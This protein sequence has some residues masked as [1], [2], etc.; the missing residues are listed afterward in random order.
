[1]AFLRRSRRRALLLSAGVLAGCASG[2][3]SEGVA[4]P[5]RRDA[6]AAPEVGGEPTPAVS[7]TTRQGA[8]GK[9]DLGPE[10]AP[11]APK[12]ELPDDYLH[13]EGACDEGPVVTIAAV[14][15]LL[16]HR[17][18]QRQALRSK[19]GFRVL[20]AG[21]ED[22]FAKADIAYANLE[23]PTAHGINRK[24]ELVEDPGRRFDNQV[25][26]GYARFNYHPSLAKDLVASGFDIVSTANNHSLDRD[27]LGVDRTLDAL[28]EAG[29]GHT[30]TR[31]AGTQEPFFAVT[32]A[33]G[34][35]IA[36]VACTLHTNF[37]KDEQGQ[38]L[39][40]FQ[41]PKLV[42]SIVSKLAA[43]PKIDAVIV[44]P[45]WG[46]EYVPEPGPKQREFA[47]AVVEAG[48]TAV[49]GSHPHVLQPWEKVTTQD[50]R[51]AFVLYSLG[52]FASH[53][54]SLPRR[55]TM[56]AY[57]GLRRRPDGVVV[58]V[59]VR[60]VPLHVRMEGDKEAFFVEAIDRADGP[61]DS[62]ALTVSM[63]GAPN[64]MGPDDALDVRPHCDPKWDPP[65]TPPK[66]DLPED[67]ETDD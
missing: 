5:P 37:G 31:R 54:R 3:S 8:Q 32:E 44:T 25:Y 9:K 11:T 48:A 60:Y 36:W 46:R 16:I 24:G 23:G 43:K 50:G 27:S 21:V 4:T 56:V 57:L 2:S 67:G 30:G 64:L 52:N 22:L 12:R 17:E 7:V 28:D 59:G 45:H 10:P 51:E 6:G 61:A 53:Q 38:V 62:R 26:S 66:P 15:D 1:M 55:S 19:Q 39:H 20:W 49:L 14:G 33:K 47:K 34:L 35:R 63:F 40:C 13:F 41:D 18:L 29:L 42:P 65:V 58:P